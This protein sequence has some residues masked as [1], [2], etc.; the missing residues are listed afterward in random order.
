MVACHI[1]VGKHRGQ[2]ET[3]ANA[4]L[5]FCLRHSFVLKKS[6]VQ[7]LRSSEYVFLNIFDTYFGVI[8]HLFR[9]SFQFLEEKLDTESQSNDPATQIPFRLLGG[10]AR[11]RCE[12][13]G[14][15][16]KKTRL[17]VLLSIF[18]AFRAPCTNAFHFFWLGWVGT[19]STFLCTFFR[20]HLPLRVCRMWRN[21]T[22]FPHSNWTGKLFIWGM[23]GLPLRHPGRLHEVLSRYTDPEVVPH[24]SEL[25]PG[26]SEQP[27][28]GGS[29]IWSLKLWTALI[30]WFTEVVNAADMDEGAR[31]KGFGGEPVAW[32]MIKDRMDLMGFFSHGTDSI[33]IYSSTFYRKK[34]VS[35]DGRLGS[36]SCKHWAKMAARKDTKTTPRANEAWDHFL[37]VW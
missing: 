8:P 1:Q 9:L 26:I 18:G 6:R 36:W 5:F 12:P 23:K 31:M 15:R 3:G 19:L 35:V 34:V 27:V 28:V 2:C 30:G 24:S 10:L 37:G 22:A 20:W 21:H 7:S 14:A 4:T 32:P 16:L 13:W 29:Q 11:R 17:F 33:W 25:L